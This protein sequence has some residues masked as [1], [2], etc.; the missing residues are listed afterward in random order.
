LKLGESYSWSY[1][2][3]CWSRDV[4][5]FDYIYFWSRKLLLG[6]G[7]I[8]NPAFFRKKTIGV[9][10]N[11]WFICLVYYMLA[12]LADGWECTT[13]SFL[14]RLGGFFNTSCIAPATRWM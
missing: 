8:S 10:T 11:I 9:K 1:G 12:I 13:V 4:L 7:R 2:F 3:S 6:N 14:C 5:W